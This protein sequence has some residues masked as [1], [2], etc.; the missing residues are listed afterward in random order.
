MRESTRALNVRGMQL[1]LADKFEPYKLV[2]EN[3]LVFNPGSFARKT[4]Q[5]SVYYPRFAE[6]K[7]RM[8]DCELPE[9]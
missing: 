4:F 6:P 7:H 1:V 9:R 2:Y 3:C 5:W 8:D